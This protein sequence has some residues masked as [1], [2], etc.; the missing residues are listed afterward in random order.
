MG[1]IEECIV[2]QL[3]KAYQQVNQ[4]ARRRLAPY[5]VTPVQYGLLEVLGETDGQSGTALGERLRLDGATI[6]GLLD[7][8]AEAGFVERRPHPTDRRINAIYLTEKGHAIQQDL[9]CAMAALAAEVLGRLSPADAAHLPAILI[10]LA[11]VET[12]GGA[13]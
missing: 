3:G 11:N 5:G 8:L 1:R 6:T 4:E 10:Q 2:F 13:R 12:V 7:R 9:D